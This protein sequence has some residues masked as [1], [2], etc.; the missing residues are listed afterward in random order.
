MKSGKKISILVADDHAVVRAGLAMIIGC[1]DDMTVV[2]EARNGNEAIEIANRL[3]P[4]VVIMDLFMPEKDGIEATKAIC[5]ASP[6]TRI[7]ILTSFATSS[8]L[9]NAVANGA[10]GVLMKD[11]PNEELVAAIRA[12]HR[13][14]KHFRGEV[15]KL[16]SVKDVL[17]PL[18]ERQIEILQSCMN[19]FNT[20]DIARQFGISRNGVKKH[21]ESIFAKLGASTRAEAVAIAIHNHLLK[22]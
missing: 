11:G 4:D 18:T 3:H 1:E 9:A 20:A 22:T 5:S 12:V 2:G 16:I 8:E 15:A 21:F 13:G 7:L 14:E 6:T 19:G 10:S 17:Q